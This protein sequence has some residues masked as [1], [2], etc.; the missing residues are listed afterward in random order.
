MW[1]ALVIVVGVGLAA[2]CSGSEPVTGTQLTMETETG[3]PT[4]VLGPSRATLRCDG[5]ALGTGFL[6]DA[7]A[8][9]C[10]LVHRGV[11]QRV[12]AGQRSQRLCSQVYGGPQNAHITGSIDGQRVSLTVTRTDG[13]GIG[14][15][16]TLEPLLGDPLRQGTADVEG[17]PSTAT[18]TTAPGP[19]T[20]QVKRGDTLTAIAK[21]FR[22][23]IAAIVAIN[24]LA[25]PDRLV[26]G[27]TLL[28]PSVPAVQLVVTPPDAPVGTGFQLKLTGAQP[29]E[30]VTFEIDAPDHKFTGTPHTASANGVAT[31]TY[32]S[33]ASDTPGTYAVIANGDKGSNARASFRVGTSG[34]G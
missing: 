9:A 29:S 24:P 7:A 2:G 6:R 5:K 32:Q 14:D 30:M 31:A 25:N 20:Y 8:P 15:W 23:P 18:P 1:R 22:V 11:V 27:Q 4:A 28:I 26:E 34:T 17:A 21:Q 33:S 12:V 3:T 10:A 19:I 13:C 16:Q